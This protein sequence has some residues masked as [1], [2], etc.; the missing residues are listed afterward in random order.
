[1]SNLCFGIVVLHLMRGD[2]GRKKALNSQQQEVSRRLYEIQVMQK[3]SEKMDT[4]LDMK[5]ITKT[6]V[7]VFQDLYDVSTITC[8]FIDNHTISLTTTMK[9]AVGEKYI[10][11]VNAIA[12]TSLHTLD[13]L[14]KGYDV[15]AKTKQQS[16]IKNYIA[17]HF[18]PSPESYFSV[19]LVL[20]N[21]LY[22]V[23]TISSRKQHFFT[24]GDMDIVY[25]VARQAIR[26]VEQL[27]SVVQIEG[28][29]LINLVSSLPTP[30]ILFTRENNSLKI[31]AANPMARQI[32]KLP[33]NPTFDDISWSVEGRVDL[34][35]YI[36]EVFQGDR[37]VFM[38][39]VVI[40]NRTYKVYINPVYT[41]SQT[42]VAGVTLSLL[43]VTLEVES[44]KIR[45]KFT[46]MVVHELRAPLTSIKGGSKLLL[47]GK[48]SQED[49]KK[50]LYIIADASDRMLIQIND[51]LDAAKL[52]AG[53][54]AVAPVPGNINEIVQQRIDAFTYLASTKEI[55]L[56]VHLDSSIKEFS[57][58]KMRVDQV[59][60]N[61]L[62][63][64]LKFTQAKGQIT[65][66]TEKSDG[67]VIVSVQDNGMGVPV[68]KQ[69]ML[70]VPF[71]QMQ[72]AF[73]RDGTGL[74]LY[75]SRG[76]IESHG[77]KIWMESVEGKGTTVS[78]SLPLKQKTTAEILPQTPLIP[79]EQKVV[80]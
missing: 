27:E 31:S 51:L 53:K 50:M 19:P 21:M 2:E 4:S 23:I 36:N 11:Q 62:S 64:S 71:S 43:D 37:S 20:N 56:S 42:E 14:T 69:N 29:R 67:K 74:G 80:N 8:A 22:G 65:V 9:E 28:S 59:I 16:D 35:R 10:Q 58:D 44:E 73:R 15:V 18:D 61:L 24:E 12:L 1:M 32:L 78:F 5:T 34:H 75:I 33:V 60:T 72:N 3:I 40:K 47:D 6:L 52:E 17:L 57:F 13:E 45:E 46:N 54:F 77:G 70:F 7:S 63:N 41:T 26:S 68:S 55:T 66:K 48:L 79:S 38:K 39:D 30:A 25:K 49:A 76:I